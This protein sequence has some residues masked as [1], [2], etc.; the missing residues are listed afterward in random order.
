MIASFE[1]ALKSNQP[2]EQLIE[3]ANELKSKGL[4]YYEIYIVFNEFLNFAINSGTR[5]QE[6]NIRN[7]L[8]LIYGWSSSKNRLFNENN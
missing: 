1:I 2:R 5:E 6:E 3:I 4:S 8:D 7:V